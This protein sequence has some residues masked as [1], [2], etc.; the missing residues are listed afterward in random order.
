MPKKQNPPRAL[1]GIQPSGVLHIGNYLGAIKQIVELQKNTEAF[2]F[3]A[4]LHALTVRLRPQ[5]LKKQTLMTAAAYLAAGIDP[6][7]AALFVQSQVP[8][9]T[10]LAWILQ[11]LTPLSALRQMHQF[12]EKSKKQGKE[13][14]AGLFAYPVL[15]A[16]DILLYDAQIVPIGEDQRQHLELTR[17]LARR[18]NRCY[19]KTLTVPKAQIPKTGAKIQ[20]LQNPTQKMSKSDPAKTYIGLFEKPDSIRE[21][22]KAA[23]TDS[24]AEIKRADQSPGIR[25]LINIYALFA[26]ISQKATVEQFGGFSYAQFKDALAKLLIEKLS[27]LRE[28]Y[29]QLLQN[30]DELYQTIDQGSKK[31][32]RVA[33]KKIERIKKTIGLL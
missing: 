21:K 28:R 10:E 5:L 17:S 16:A 13:V 27:P 23:V 15:Q 29:N 7:K 18:F 8:A 19:G 22:I 3:I 11:T 12:K 9:H 30:P 33:N 6:N 14:N 25:N 20:N 1:S 26:G 32:N 2:Y 24:Y 31:A 4:D